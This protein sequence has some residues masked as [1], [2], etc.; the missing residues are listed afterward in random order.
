MILFIYM[1][2]CIL[3]LDIYMIVFVYEILIKSLKI[4]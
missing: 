1:E 4:K 2:L 3:V